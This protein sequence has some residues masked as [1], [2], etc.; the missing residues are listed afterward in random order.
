MGISHNF[1]AFA[2][3]YYL[4][5]DTLYVWADGGLIIRDSA[6]LKSDR[7]GQIQ[8]GESVVVQQRKYYR[9]DEEELTIINKNQDEKGNKFLPVKIQG[10]WVKIKY[11]DI[12]GFVFDGYLS[13]MPAPTLSDHGYLNLDGYLE[14][15]FTALSKT[16][17]SEGN[18]TF[19]NQTFSEGISIQ[20]ISSQTG[21]SRYV[22]PP[23]SLEELLL[24]LKNSK[25]NQ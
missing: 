12:V 3:N 14:K 8:Y 9:Y 6:N 24:I 21:Y 2:I 4:T 22:L 13:A 16:E 25:Q 18:Y 15:H 10:T 19:T 20:T 23:F 7:I 1:P 17:R 11:K 5:G